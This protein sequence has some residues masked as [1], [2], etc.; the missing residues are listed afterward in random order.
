MPTTYEDAYDTI[1]NQVL[2][3]WPAAALAIVGSAV[4]MR[5]TGVEDP[6]IPKDAFARFTMQSV[7]ERQATLRDGTNGQ[8][9][10][11]E[12]LIHIQVFT[13]RSN[14][15]AEELGRKLAVLAQSIFRGKSFDGCIWFR[16]V[17]INNL[18]PERNFIRKTM[19]AEYRYDE[20]G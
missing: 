4:E 10:T 7:F 16:N 15:R 11:A 14:D 3:D 19:I 9:Y 20:I 6:D 5:F 17:R 1:T 18:E 13:P 2:A 12:G 8:S